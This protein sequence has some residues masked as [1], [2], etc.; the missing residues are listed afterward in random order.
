MG[1]LPNLGFGGKVDTF[2]KDKQNSMAGV[3]LPVRF[4]KKKTRVKRI[5]RT[6]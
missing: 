1:I 2:N 3:S 6:G 4:E 5:Q